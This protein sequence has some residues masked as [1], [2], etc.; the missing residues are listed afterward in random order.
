MQSITRKPGFWGVFCSG[1]LVVFMPPTLEKLK[2]PTAFD[3]YGHPAICVSI[4]NLIQ[5]FEVS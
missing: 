2:R 4:Q 5:G 1:F 3:S